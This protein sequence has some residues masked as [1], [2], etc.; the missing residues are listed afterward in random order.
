MLSPSA[1]ARRRERKACVATTH[2]LRK[3]RLQSSDVIWPIGRPA[4]SA[5]RDTHGTLNAEGVGGEFVIVRRLR[6]NWLEGYR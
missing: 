5:L 1:S 6:T 4:L 3:Q 2:S